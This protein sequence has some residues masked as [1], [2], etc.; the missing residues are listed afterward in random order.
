MLSDENVWHFHRFDVKVDLGF[1]YSTGFAYLHSVG[2]EV[3]K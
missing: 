3:W 1:F 2:F